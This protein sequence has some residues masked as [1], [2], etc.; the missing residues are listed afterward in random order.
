[1]C[2][3]STGSPATLVVGGSFRA[4][5]RNAQQPDVRAGRRKSAAPL[6]FTLEVSKPSSVKI[7]F[8]CD[9]RGR[10]YFPCP[11]IVKLVKIG[12]IN[13]SVPFILRFDGGGLYLLVHP[14]IGPFS[15]TVWL[16]SRQISHQK[17]KSIAILR[18][19]R[20]YGKNWLKIGNILMM[21]LHDAAGYQL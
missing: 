1:M 16:C 8:S 12:R 7:I 6:N 11:C 2:D 21:W 4:Q 19:D 17:K 9:K 10:I 15:M 3:I 5:P 18:T 20:R 13:K 14:C